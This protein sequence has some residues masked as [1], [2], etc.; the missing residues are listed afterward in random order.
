MDWF[1]YDNGFRLER[2]KHKNLNY[3]LH[4]VYFSFKKLL[5]FVYPKI[6]EWRLCKI[7]ISKSF[8]GKI[9][10][11]IPQNSQEYTCAGVSLQNVSSP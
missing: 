11:K 4:Q 10:L 9:F 2:V 8:I 6:S 7:F 5:S 3:K 1:L